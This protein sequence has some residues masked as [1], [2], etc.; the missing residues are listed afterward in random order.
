MRTWLS[1]DNQP[2]A[3]KLGISNI[4]RRSKLELLAPLAQLTYSCTREHCGVEKKPV[5]CISI[6]GKGFK[7]NTSVITKRGS[8]FILLP[9]K[10]LF[11]PL[12][13]TPITDEFASLLKEGLLE[14]CK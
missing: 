12:F 5:A 2:L 9:N 7:K 10:N 4:L 11:A 14:V 1:V 3:S 8:T 6:Q 13:L